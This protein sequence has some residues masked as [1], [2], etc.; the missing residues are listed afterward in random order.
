MQITLNNVT[1]IYLKGEPQEVKALNKINITLEGSGIVALIGSTG[2]GK[3]TLLQTLNGLIKPTEGQIIIDGEDITRKGARLLSIPKRIGLVFQYPE[4]Q[5]FEESVYEDLAFG[6]KNLDLT[7]EDIR[8]RVEEAAHLVGLEKEI[9]SMSPFHL[10]GGQKRRVAI[11]GVLAMGPE[12]LVLD[13]PTAGLDPRGREEILGQLQR[14]QR[15]KG[16]LILLATHRMEEAATLAQRILV[17]HRGEL[18]LDGTPK[19]VF[20]KVERLE[21]IHLDV[22]P[23]TRLFYL[24]NQRGYRVRQDILHLKEAREEIL[25]LLGKGL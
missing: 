23:L 20:S 25:S 14:L 11:A 17:L 21:E 16:L 15:E 2:S 10:S 3:S 13:E 5:L 18:V 1:H 8:Q 12:V 4:H 6:P 19:E 22:P 9:L 24:L 7:E